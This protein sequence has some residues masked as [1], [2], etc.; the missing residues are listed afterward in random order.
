MD[1]DH[2]RVK[3]GV[4]VVTKDARQ[5]EKNAQNALKQRKWRTMKAMVRA[6]EKL[7]KEVPE[8]EFI[9]VL[10]YPGSM[11]FAGSGAMLDCFKK[12][13]PLTVG[14]P[15]GINYTA[16][17]QSEVVD[18][19]S[20]PPFVEVATPECLGTA[21]TGEQLQEMY[22]SVRQQ[23]I[24]D[25]PQGA[26]LDVD[27]NPEPAAREPKRVRKA[28]DI[29]SSAGNISG[30]E[31][32]PTRTTRGRAAARDITAE[33]Q[34]SPTRTTRRAAA[35]DVQASQTQDNPA[36][37]PTGSMSVASIRPEAFVYVSLPT[38]SNRAVPFVSEVTSENPLRV[39][40]L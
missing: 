35:R 27:D 17:T 3:P 10:S 12:G 28:H 2:S 25:V 11:K 9:I 5:M 16:D 33:V 13:E 20:T 26:Q 23:L 32:L 30:I 18:F 36:R 31:P 8:M 6:A 15:A 14:K 39:K 29:V 1:S 7:Q 38:Q 40:Y 37:G 21:T 34:A 4:K 24:P 19:L 22:N